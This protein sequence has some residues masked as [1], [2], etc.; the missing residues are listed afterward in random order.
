M[1][2]TPA[3]ANRHR[4]VGTPSRRVNSRIRRRQ[5]GLVLIL[6]GVVAGLV[7]GP[8]V[9][10]TLATTVSDDDA[11]VELRLDDAAATL[12]APAGWAVTQYPVGRDTG[13]L[14]SPDGAL[15]V[16]LTLRE[17]G[18]PL[19]SAAQQLLESAGARAA[20][21]TGEWNVERP[22]PD[23][24]VQHVD[25]T[26]VADRRPRWEAN[27]PA[28]G[29]LAVAASEPG[30]VGS[31]EPPYVVDVVAAFEPGTDAAD[32]RATIAQLLGSLEVSS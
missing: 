11:P 27:K 32:Y 9:A 15:H 31:A 26:A 14:R 5:A 12:V 25:A 2:Q 7:W 19:E 3:R 13:E 1:S 23:L 10:R 20:T 21:S 18:G 30:T 17:A 22:R 28:V 4:A 16:V 6:V 24:V 29:F 8:G